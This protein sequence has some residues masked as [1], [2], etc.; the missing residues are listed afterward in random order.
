MPSNVLG[1]REYRGEQAAPVAC[2][3][4]AYMLVL[5]SGISNYAHE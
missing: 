5:E 1:A 4:G 3:L 2:S